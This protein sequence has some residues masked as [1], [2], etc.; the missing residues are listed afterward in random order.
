MPSGNER[1]TVGE[2]FPSK[3]EKYGLSCVLLKTLV[4]SNSQ[5][6][7]NRLSEW[8]G[9]LDSGGAVLKELKG[10]E[11]VTDDHRGALRTRF[12]KSKYLK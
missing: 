4:S 10:M 1:A 7:M 11:N 3:D 12:S 9:E 6:T 2:M 5:E 8:I